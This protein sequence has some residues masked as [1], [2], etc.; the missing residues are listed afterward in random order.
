M[1]IK[2]HLPSLMFRSISTFIVLL[3]LLFIF[4]I[5]RS[6]QANQA[7]V[8]GVGFYNFEN[9]FDTE[10]DPKIR[11]EEFLP[12][13]PKKW[14][15]NK[16]ED[17]I[18]K[19][20]KVVSGLGT[21]LTPD[22]LAVLGVSEVENKKVLEDFCKAEQ[23]KDKNYKIIHFDSPD[24]R[25]IDVALLFQEKYFKVSNSKTYPL[26][27]HSDDGS[28]RFTR[29]ILLVS[30]KFMGEEMHFLV[31]H[32]PSRSGGEQISRPARNKAATINKG[33]IDSLRS[34][35]SDAKVIVMGDMN[36][37]PDNE[38]L[39]K[40]LGGERKLNKVKEGGIF[41]PMYRNYCKGIGSNAWRDAWS[42]FDQI[43]ITEPLIDADT[44]GFKYH[45]VR[46]YNEKWMTQQ[47]GQFKGYPLR[48][49]V[50]DDYKGGY[51]DHFP[52]YIFLVKKIGD[53]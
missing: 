21:E 10:D 35:N 23:V 13:G 44:P 42:L 49:F 1:T 22:G 18:S 37:N 30:G 4:Q 31:N 34:I 48:S 51:S 3:P 50:G 24:R 45:K 33:I 41:N 16:Y 17:K 2:N 52:V 38:S 11:D 9:L 20:A 8:A 14:D 43:L 5:A 40:I 25:G 29:D 27:L 39:K 6:Q 15:K 36:D 47:E 7:I 32:W 26:I 53:S 12:D 28:R 46:I 19:L